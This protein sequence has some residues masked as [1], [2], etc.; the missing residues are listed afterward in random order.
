MLWFVSGARRRLRSK[1]AAQMIN[2][3]SGLS[4]K[5]IRII[6]PLLVD[7]PSLSG[8]ARA[9]RHRLDVPNDL[10]KDRG[11]LHVRPV[12]AWCGPRSLSPTKSACVLVECAA[13]VL[14]RRAGLLVLTFDENHRQRPT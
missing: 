12:G 14:V 1:I 7:T 3:S 5:R 13:E 8:R 6:A 10:T 4:I 11:G 2:T 9:T